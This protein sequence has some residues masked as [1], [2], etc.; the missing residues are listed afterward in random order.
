MK[1]TLSE[2]R[3][4]ADRYA[5]VGGSAYMY[6]ELECVRPSTFLEGYWDVGFKV[7]DMEGNEVDGP[8][9]MAIDDNTGIISSIDEVI[10]KFYQRG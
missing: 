3:K 4:I 10:M 9:L 7:K 1:L 6:L 2:A 5:M 8:L